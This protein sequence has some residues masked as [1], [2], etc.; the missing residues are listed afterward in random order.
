MDL[1]TLKAIYLACGGVGNKNAND[2]FNIIQEA[3][4]EEHKVKCDKLFEKYDFEYPFGNKVRLN[5]E[6]YEW[7]TER[8]AKNKRKEE[9]KKNWD[10]QRKGCIGEKKAETT[11]GRYKIIL[12]NC[13]TLEKE[14]FMEQLDSFRVEVIDL[15]E[16]VYRFDFEPP[17]VGSD[18]DKRY[19]MIGLLDR[20]KEAKFVSQNNNY[21]DIVIDYIKSGIGSRGK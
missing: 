14:K 8:R 3:E 7:L 21:L 5:P 10:E 2:L 12:H 15:G 16:P 1:E 17:K 9:F 13:D 19:Y 11:K 6:E 18:D 4:R 20:V